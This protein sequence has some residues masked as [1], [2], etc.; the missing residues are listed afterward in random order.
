VSNGGFQAGTWI[1]LP[2]NCTRSFVLTYAR[3]AE[4]GTWVLY[5]CLLTTTKT[6]IKCISWGWKQTKKCSWWSFLFCLLWAI[7]VTA[8]C[9]AAGIFVITICWVFTLV[10]LVVCLLWTLVSVIFCLSTANGG[11]AFL[12]TDGTVM[13]QESM[14]SDLY[15]LGIPLQAYGTNRWWKLTPDNFGSYANGSWSR[16]ADSA[17]GRTFYASAV[18]A[19][20]RVVFCG[21]EYSDASGMIQEDWT[22]TCEIYDPVTNSW[23]SFPPPT[24]P[25][26]D[27]V[28]Q[29][30]G[31]APCA[32]LPQGTFLIGS[33]GDL[34]V[35]KLYPATLTWE[36]MRPRPRLAS[37][38]GEDSWVLMPDNTI[39]APSC[40]NPPTTWVY[41]IATNEWQKGN[42]L[43]PPPFGIVDREDHEIGPGL[44]RY[45]GTAFFIGANEHTGVYS[46]NASPQ[47]SN[48]PDLPDQT[49][50]GI[51]TAIGIHDGPA[52][53]LVNGNILFGAGVKVGTAQTSPSW[54][55][56]FDG[57][58]FN[59]TTD[60]PNNVTLT[61]ATR[62]LLLPNGD[63]LFCRE[64]DNSF[65]AYHSESAQPEDS[66][67]PVIEN[68]PPNLSPGSTIQVSGIQF[69]GLSQAN[70][71]GDDFTNATNYP[72]VRI[73]NNETSHVRYCRTHDHTTV[74]SNGKVKTSMGVAIGSAVIT[75]QVDIPND[76]DLGDAQL[77]VVANG[78]PSQ[79]FPVIIGIIIQ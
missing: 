64:D 20:G 33:I 32:L 11:A 42:D 76:I 65:Y 60:P 24:L 31:D 5:R 75:T 77:F 26:S 57:T 1:T 74:D 28:W 51:P 73:V 19:D 13:M 7:V 50:N 3:C 59:R 70:G 68:C 54:F 53:V 15:F 30:I 66:F 56:E 35:A 52:T 49:V 23:T 34:N 12:L 14:S 27:Q 40:Q 25:D 61:F 37:S 8:V 21:G 2:T 79:P 78:I 29:Q 55:F 44:L 10:E 62:M 41:Q 18:L 6:I 22:N 36:A 58:T 17:V 47:W 69:N 39:A 48:G 16:L 4:W 63:A 38:S 72:L 45:D 9:L 43:P 71:F 46:P 67:R